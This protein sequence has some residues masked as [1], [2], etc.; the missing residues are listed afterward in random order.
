MPEVDF[1]IRTALSSDRSRL[2]NLIHFGAYLHQHLDWKPAIDWVGSKPYLVLENGND[3]VA[4]LACPPDLPDIT[5]IR[6]FATNSVIDTRTAWN[7]LWDAA[8]KELSA[9]GNMRVAAISLQNWFNDLLQKSQFDHSDDVVVLM[10]ENMPLRSETSIKNITVRP[11]VMEDLQVIEKIDHAAFGPV[12]KNSLESLELAYQQSS[13]CTVA[14]RQDEIVGYQYSTISSMG[15]HLARLAVEPALQGNGIGYLLV[16]QLLREFSRN[17]IK[18][19][20][21]NTQRSNMA[22]LA[23]YSKVGFNFTG[24]AYQVFQTIIP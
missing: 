3:I 9:I 17:G 1:S 7:K 6:L 8:F 12:W 5:W 18:H 19:I 2:V 11:M 23:L 10:W 22:S 4:T 24:E 13:I 16:N 21:V 20:T 14:E 15:G